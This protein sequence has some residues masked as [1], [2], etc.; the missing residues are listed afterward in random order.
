MAL[1]NQRKPIT[2]IKFPESPVTPALPAA[3]IPG[4]MMYCAICGKCERDGVNEAHAWRYI[5]IKRRGF[6]VCPDHF[7]PD[8]ASEEQQ[9]DSLLVVVRQLVQIAEISGNIE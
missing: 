1:N 2:V 3:P 4:F 8:T 7:A 9:K 6:H 5:T